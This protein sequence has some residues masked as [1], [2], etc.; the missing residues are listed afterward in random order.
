MLA[1]MTRELS[2]WR[3]VIPCR[4]PDEALRII[5]NLVKPD[6]TTFEDVAKAAIGKRVRVVF[7][8]LA[9]HM[10]LP[11]FTLSGEPDQGRVWRLGG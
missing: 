11:Q 7:Q 5:G 6:A 2:R 9:D 8:D 3:R 10:A 4:T 1:V